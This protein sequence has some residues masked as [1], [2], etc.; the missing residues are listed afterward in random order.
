[1]GD[2]NDIRNGMAAV[3][4]HEL[5]SVADGGPRVYSHR[6]SSMNP[7]FLL[8]SPTEGRRHAMGGSRKRE[9]QFSI[10]VVIGKGMEDAN[11]DVK[12]DDYVSTD[13]ALSVEAAL[14]R[15]PSLDG[16]SELLNFEG[17]TDYGEEIVVNGIAYAGARCIVTVWGKEPT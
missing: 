1:M 15:E 4:E 10:F 8:V 2:L 6:R 7:P 12:A 13:G 11:W 9:L 14:L 17:F 3:L 16:T 5:P